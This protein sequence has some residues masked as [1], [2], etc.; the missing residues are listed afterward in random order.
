MGNTDEQISQH[1]RLNTDTKRKIVAALQTLFDQ[2]NELIR[3]F[4]TAF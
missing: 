3:F 4:R 1:F 2:H